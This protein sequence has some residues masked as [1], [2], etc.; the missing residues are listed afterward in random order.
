MTNT[1]PVL[2]ASTKDLLTASAQWQDNTY[3]S[4]GEATV[5]SLDLLWPQKAP[6]DDINVMYLSLFGSSR[7]NLPE[8]S[9]ILGNTKTLAITTQFDDTPKDATLP[10][11][12]ATLVSQDA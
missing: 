11:K 8:T 5:T 1:A 10:P 9:A 7:G 3:T 12:I 6:E 4:F 2:P